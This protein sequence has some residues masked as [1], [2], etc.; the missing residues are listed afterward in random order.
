MR[1][2]GGLFLPTGRPT[3]EEAPVNIRESLTFDDVLLVPQKSG[4]LPAEVSTDSHFTREILLKLPLASAAMD[5]VT[6]SRMAIAMAQSGGIGVVHKNLSVE[7]QTAQVARVKRAES[8]M[9]AEPI[10]IAPD[11][12]IGEARALMGQ[13]GISGLPVVDA[14]MRLVGILTKRDL[15]F[16]DDWKLPVARVMTAEGL[17]TAPEGTTLRRAREI[18]RKHR[19]EK[20]P[21]VDRRHRL[22]GLITTK[23]I[24]KRVENPQATLDSLRR[25]KVAAAVGVGRD[26][27][28]RTEA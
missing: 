10:S 18:L 4:V 17:I 6:E 27:F 2:R 24:L 22:R 7:E 1:R 21:I 13:Y 3:G 19:I 28:V 14:K 8:S 23:D 25:L 26:A 11:K 15:L 20:L 16:Q 9:I 5:T 12:T